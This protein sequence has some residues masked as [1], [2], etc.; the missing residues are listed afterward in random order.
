MTT[1]VAT[2]METGWKRLLK[3]LLWQKR[4]P[5]RL[6]PATHLPTTNV[7]LPRHPTS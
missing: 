4:T 2:T 3:R 5:E 7:D 6:R 1:V